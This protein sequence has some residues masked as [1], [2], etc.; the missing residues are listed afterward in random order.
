MRAHSSVDTSISNLEVFCYASEEPEEEEGKGSMA[1][2]WSFP[3][4]PDSEG[5]IERC[6]GESSSVEEEE[7]VVHIDEASPAPGPDAGGRP[8]MRREVAPQQN[9]TNRGRDFSEHSFWVFLQTKKLTENLQHFILHSI[10]MVTPEIC[11]G[12]GLR[13][14][15]H[16]LCCLGRYGNTPFLFPLYGRGRSLSASAGCGLCLEGSTVFT[17]QFSVW[18]WTRSP[19]SAKL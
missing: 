16:F 14:T 1:A 10:A 15:Q 18:L 8:N 3:Q 7:P 12:E 4:T 17:T 11:M 6:L 5:G 9:K 13:A 19:A 2:A